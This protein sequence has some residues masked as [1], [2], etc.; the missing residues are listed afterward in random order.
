MVKNIFVNLPIKNLHN[1]VTFFTALGFTFN[2]KFTDATSTC[3]VISESIFA[4]LVEEDKFTTFTTKEICDSTKKT[5]VLLALQV[6]KRE[7]VDVLVNKALEA[8]GTQH[9]PAQD[10][11]FM[12]AHSFQDI[13]GHI[14]EVFYMEDAK[15]K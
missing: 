12:Y 13:D 7:K 2:P 11:G 6:E 3:M 5:E 15:E 1:T 9:M 8:G 4:M 14:W 10:H